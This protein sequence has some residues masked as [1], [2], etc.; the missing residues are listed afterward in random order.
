MQNTAVVLI[1]AGLATGLGGLVALHLAPTGLSAIRN[2]VSQYGITSYRSGYRIQTIGYAVAGLGAAIGIFTLPGAAAGPAGLC[3]IFAAA[4]A[5]ISWFPMDAPGAERTATGRG[6]GVL[7]AAAFV[8]AGLAAW[9]LARLLRHDGLHPA[10]ATI[11]AVLAAV[12]AI[13]LL[14]MVTSR[15]AG[16]GR[17]GLIERG[18]YLTMTAWLATVAVLGVLPG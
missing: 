7:A 1:A 16:I 14:A 2:A 12:M 13:T 10:I 3:L 15:R 11:S 9:Q 6:H 5:L 17:F 18:F 4:R 8:C